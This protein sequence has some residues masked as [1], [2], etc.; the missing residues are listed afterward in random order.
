MNAAGA[1]LLAAAL[2]GCDL[3]RGQPTPEPCGREL[4]VAGTSTVASC[5]PTLLVVDVSGLRG[6]GLA[7]RSSFFGPDRDTSLTA[8]GRAVII[9]ASPGVHAPYVLTISA[10]P[11]APWQ[12][13]TLG[14]DASGMFEDQGEVIVPLTCTTNRYAVGGT[15]T[16]VAAGGVSLQFGS[17]AVHLDAEGVF[18]FATPVESGAPWRV[19]ATVDPTQI[20][21]VAGGSGTMAGEDVRS[22][23]VACDC[24]PPLARAGGACTSG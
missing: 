13:C 15:V 14:G 10:H 17:E 23:Q 22:V 6:S 18:T 4:H 24:A 21:T 12:T 9:A 2:A 1:A 16:G 11:V 3:S 20:C 19:T 8:D 5:G 7:V